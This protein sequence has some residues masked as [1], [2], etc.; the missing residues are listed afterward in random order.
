MS[1]LN[2]IP[3]VSNSEA[4]TLSHTG[5]RANHASEDSVALAR[6]TRDAEMFEEDWPRRNA[7]RRTAVAL[8]KAT[9]EDAAG[10]AAKTHD[11]ANALR[12]PGT[13]A[14]VHFES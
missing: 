2:F 5:P 1:I 10:A 9:P 14:H 3:A 4:P 6:G 13:S 8:V 12:L 11:D 7:K